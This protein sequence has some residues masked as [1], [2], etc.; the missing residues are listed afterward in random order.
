[1]TCPARRPG[2]ASI[3]V[4]SSSACAIRVLGVLT[5][6]GC[7]VTALAQTTGKGWVPIFNGKNL[8]GWYTFLPSTGKNND[9]KGVFK[10]HDGMIHVLDVSVTGEKQEYGY[11]ATENEYSNFRI[12][13]E[14]KWGRKRFPPR[15]KAKR[16]AGI[17]YHFVGPDKVWPRSVECQVQET[18]T[19]DFWLVDGTSL[20]TTVESEENLTY[21]EGGSVYTKTGGR[22]I[23]SADY[24]NREGWNTVEVILDADRVTHMV[25]GKV[26]N[27]GWDLKQPDPEHPGRMIPLTKGRMVFQAEGAEIFYRNIQVKPLD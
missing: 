27:R 7:L 26:N 3:R 11:I 21:A 10:V 2:R 16:D 24:E 4:G 22:I 1:M 6:A 15:D 9:P 5:L 13:F 18:D 25:N 8:D 14:Y 20:T 12:R 17:L 19:G 23:K